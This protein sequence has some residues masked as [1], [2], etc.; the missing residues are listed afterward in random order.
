LFGLTFYLE[1]MTEYSSPAQ[2]ADEF[3]TEVPRWEL[4]LGAE[5]SKEL[6]EKDAMKTFLHEV[7]EFSFSLSSFVAKNDDR[8]NLLLRT[9]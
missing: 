5:L 4:S 9:L 6:S 8:F 2:N 3:R 7:W 1:E